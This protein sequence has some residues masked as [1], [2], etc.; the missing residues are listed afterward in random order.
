MSKLRSLIF[1][2][3]SKIFSGSRQKWLTL[4]IDSRNRLLR[5]YAGEHKGIDQDKGSCHIVDM[6]LDLAPASKPQ[7][8]KQSTLVAR[9]ARTHTQRHEYIYTCIYIYINKYV[10]IYYTYIHTDVRKQI[11][12]SYICIICVYIETYVCI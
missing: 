6:L 1:L 3:S 11:R 4:F 7:K 5:A 12:V 8:Q 9:V 10:H 2:N